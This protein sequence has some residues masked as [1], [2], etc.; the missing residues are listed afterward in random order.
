LDEA[1]NKLYQADQRLGQIFGYFSML[2]IL[3]ACLGMFGLSSFAVEQRTKEIG[4]R[5][6]LGASVS[7]II[8]LVSK[9][10]TKLVVVAFI[11][12][13]PVGYLIIN[14]WLQN[15][16]YRVEIDVWTFVLVGFMA[17]II[18]LVVVSYH[19]IKA[20]LTNPV[21]TLRYE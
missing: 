1:L 20:A 13:A 15:F 11:V 6:V 10:F 8:L 16:A 19:S 5:K 14:R 3:I 12:A 17:L 9:D 7:K 2:A 18:A 21:N 4:V